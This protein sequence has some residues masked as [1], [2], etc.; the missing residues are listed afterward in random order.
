MH[1]LI[2]LLWQSS[3][4][5]TDQVMNRMIVFD[6]LTYDQWAII[7]FLY[8]VRSNDPMLLSTFYFFSVLKTEYKAVAQKLRRSVVIK[9]EPVLYLTTQPHSSNSST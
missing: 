7:G 3:L 1:S 2:A 9:Y 4:D 5:S 6:A 8:F